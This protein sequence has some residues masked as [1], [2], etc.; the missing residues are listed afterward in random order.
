MN[1]R[2]CSRLRG[3][4][5]RCGRARRYRRAADRIRRDRRRRERRSRSALV[6]QVERGPFRAWSFF[7]LSGQWRCLAGSAVSLTATK[8][9]S[10][11]WRALLVGGRP[12]DLPVAS[13]ASSFVARTRRWRTTPQGAL[14]QMARFY[15]VFLARR[16]ANIVSLPFVK[17]ESA[18]YFAGRTSCGHFTDDYSAPA[19]WAPRRRSRRR[20][21]SFAGPMRRSSQVRTWRWT[22]G[23]ADVAGRRSGKSR[24]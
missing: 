16:I 13:N 5:H 11:G 20:S 10:R 2:W 17:P 21:L 15:A 18:A 1:S 23:F 9:L 24:A 7:A 14:R 3:S 8:S 12:L 22:A 6:R 19:A 4:K